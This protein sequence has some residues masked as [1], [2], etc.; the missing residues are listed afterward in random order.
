MNTINELEKLKEKLPKIA[1]ENIQGRM[2][3]Y[4][5]LALGNSKLRDEE[6][7]ALRQYLR[8]KQHRETEYRKRLISEMEVGLAY[9]K[10]DVQA[11]LNCSPEYNMEIECE[12]EYKHLRAYASGISDLLSA[13]MQNNSILKLELK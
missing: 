5:Q 1:E 3:I 9:N 10:A 6:G 2:Q 7:V 11:R 12:A 4:E 13:I 8:A